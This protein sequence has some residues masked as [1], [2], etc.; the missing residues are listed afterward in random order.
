MKRPILASR[1]S[2]TQSKVPHAEKEELHPKCALSSRLS[3]QPS[4]YEI[5][6]TE[7]GSDIMNRN[8][9]SERQLKITST[10]RIPD[11]D[12]TAANELSVL[13]AVEEAERDFARLRI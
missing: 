3:G 6:E 8:I 12:A 11:D 10:N 1:C 9:G 4:T 5:F 7:G 2:S 13:P